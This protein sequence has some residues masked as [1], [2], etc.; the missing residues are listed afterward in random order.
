MT[1]P[2][3]DGLTQETYDKIIKVFRSFFEI[4]KV[5]LYGSRA[6]GTYKPGSDIDLTLEGSS[7]NTT[8]LLHIENDLDDLLLPHKIDL[9]IYRLID[10]TSLKNNIDKDGVVFYQK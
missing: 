4:E 2:R 7:L 1:S 5:I 3:K 9:S 6:K 10:N 8:L